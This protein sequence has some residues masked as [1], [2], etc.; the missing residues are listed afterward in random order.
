LPLRFLYANLDGVEVSSGKPLVGLLPNLP[1]YI[2]CQKLRAGIDQREDYH[3]STR[4][5]KPLVFIKDLNSFTAP[6]CLE[7]RVSARQQGA[8]I[9]SV[10]DLFYQGFESDE[11]EDYPCAVQIAFDCNRDLIVVSVEGLSRAIGEYEKMGR[12]KV[13]IVLLYFDA[14]TA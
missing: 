9:Q 1:R 11:V 7:T 10:T 4:E 13:K 5:D 8:M 3:I 6:A 14:E 2:F 12:G